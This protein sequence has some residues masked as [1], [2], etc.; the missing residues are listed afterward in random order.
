MTQ[1][2]RLEA[3]GDGEPV[4]SNSD[5]ASEHSDTTVDESISADRDDKESE[6][7]DGWSGMEDRD[8]PP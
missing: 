6:S 3:L 2:E 1:D 7:P 5:F 8:G 4:D